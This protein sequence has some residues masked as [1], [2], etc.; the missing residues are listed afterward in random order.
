MS[1]NKT[2]DERFAA[3]YERA[4]AALLD[5]HAELC[6]RCARRYVTPGTRGAALG[7]CE[8]CRLRLQTSAYEQA[9][10][11]LAAVQEGITARKRR[12]DLKR[13]KEREEAE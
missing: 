1:K 4:V 9:T 5:P 11:E 2:M 8:T 7:I 12:T 6:P 13:R 10:A 3:A